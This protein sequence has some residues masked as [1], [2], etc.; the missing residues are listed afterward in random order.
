MEALQTATSLRQAIS[1]IIKRLRRTVKSHNSYSLSEYSALSYLYPDQKLSAT[2]LAG[3][4][5]V[6]TQSMSELLINLKNQDIIDKTPHETDK[7]KSLISL[8]QKGREILEKSRYEKDEWLA[9][10]IENT[11]SADEKRTLQE[12]VAIL[13]KIVAYESNI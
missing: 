7:R 9:Q 13:H 12:A 5:R 11:L 1:G 3:L 6:K 4:V 8:T 2:E 10:A